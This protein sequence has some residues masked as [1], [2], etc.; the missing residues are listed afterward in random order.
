MAELAQEQVLAVCNG[1]T[2]AQQIVNVFGDAGVNL[3]NAQRIIG[4]RLLLPRKQYSSYSQLEGAIG[5]TARLMQ[6][7]T[8]RVSW[9]D[10]PVLLLP[11]RLETRFIGTELLVRIYPDLVSINAHDP[12][13]MQAVRGRRGSQ[14]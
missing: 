2:L 11:V 7:Y 12:R 1:A 5:A 14:Q 13:L 6:K 10:H 4:V 8:P 9:T 3:V